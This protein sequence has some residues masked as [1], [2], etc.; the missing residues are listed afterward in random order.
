MQR[1]LKAGPFHIKAITGREVTGIFLVLGNMD[2]Y[3]DRIWPGSF[4]KTFQERGARSCISGSTTAPPIA[5]IKSL[6][7]VGPTSPA[8]VLAEAPDALGGAEVVREYL[9]TPRG[10][11]CSRR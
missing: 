4:A 7:E 1:Q 10:T 9:P 11:R 3:D 6:R 5:V 2:D 8:P